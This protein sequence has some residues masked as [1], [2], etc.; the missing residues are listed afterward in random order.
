MA[1]V[2]AA[3]GHQQGRSPPSIAGP[4]A[5]CSLDLVLWWVILPEI[6]WVGVLLMAEIRR[7]PVEV[8]SLSTIIYSVSHPGGAGFQPSTVG[9]P[10]G[11]AGKSLE[12]MIVN[13]NDHHNHQSNT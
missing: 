9:C 3:R 10:V 12:N 1:L 13:L 5:E 7:A 11:S 8:G 4:M 6:F 2:R